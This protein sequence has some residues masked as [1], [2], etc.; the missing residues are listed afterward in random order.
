MWAFRPYSLFHPIRCWRSFSLVYST[1]YT[2][3]GNGVHSIMMEK[4]AQASEDGGGVH[5]HPLSL[6]LTSGQIHYPY[7]NSTHL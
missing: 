7:V 5:A 6:Y 3:S 2:Q 1:E 4:L